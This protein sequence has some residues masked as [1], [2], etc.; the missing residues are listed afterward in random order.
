[1]DLVLSAH[2]L[3]DLKARS[4][5]L[6]PVV[7][8]GQAGVSNAFYAALNLALDQHQLVK[9]KFES[10]KSER[11][12]LVPEIAVEVQ[13]RVILFVGNTVTL[14]RPSPNPQ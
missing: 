4:Q 9:V 6:Q 5:K 1:M 14:Y 13:A 10:F 8:I 2:A 7:R 3:R 12:R 11:K